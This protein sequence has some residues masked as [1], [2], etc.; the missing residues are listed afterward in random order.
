MKTHHPIP[1]AVAAS[2]LLAG[3]LHAAPI[4][5]ESFN[6]A[7]SAFPAGLE[8]KN[9]G[10]GWGGPWKEFGSS[11]AN[12]GIFAGGI[13]VTSDIA[14]PASG[15]HARVGG[16]TI[17]VGI[18]RNLPAPIGTDETT[19]WISYRTQNNNSSA[20]EEFAVFMT[21]M[22]ETH[23]VLVGATRTVGGQSASDGKFDLANLVAPNPNA[24]IA[25]RDTANHFVVL[26]FDFGVGNSDTV[27]AF[28]DP[29]STT[30][31]NGTGSARL[32]GINATFDGIAFTAANATVQIDE[33]RIGTTLTDVLENPDPYLAAASS[34]SIENHGGPETIEI[35]F[36]NEGATTNLN[37]TGVIVSGPDAAFVTSATADS[38]VAP[39]ESGMIHLDFDPT[40]AGG[41]AGFYQVTLTVA[42]NDPFGDFQTTVNVNVIS[43]FAEV[44]PAALNYGA[45]DTGDGVR[46]LEVTITNSSAE[47]LA[48]YGI[49]VTGADAAAFT[50][51]PNPGE[52]AA[53][54]S[55]V[56]H[57]AFDPALADG[58]VTAALEI[59]TDGVNQSFFTVPLTA[60]VA[61]P[62]PDSSLV[63]HF[64]FESAANPGQDTGLYGNDGTPVGDAQQSSK[65]RVG[66]GSLLLDGTGDLIDLGV[67]SGADYTTQ[68]IANGEGFTLCA[69]GFIPTAAPGA[70]MRFFSSYMPG[71]FV[72]E[73]WGAG[74]VETDRLVG[75]AFGKTDYYPANGTAPARGQWHHFAYVFRNEPIS[76]VDYYVDGAL[77]SSIASATTGVNPANTVGFCIGAL[78]LAGQTQYF[79][80]R[81]DDLRIYDRELVPA[82]ILAIYNAVPPLAGYETWAGSF[83]LDPFGNGAPGQDADLDGVANAIEY[84][85]GS[86]PVNGGERGL[87]QSTR[88]GGQFVVTYQRKLAA[89]AEGFTDRV[90]F[91]PDL[92]NTAAWTT[93]VHGTGGVIIIPTPV[94]AN[95]EQVEVRIPTGGAT[96]MFGRVEVATP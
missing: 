93:A 36:S 58:F 20:T 69:W 12:N 74:V 23:R 83:G 16:A 91:G 27:T 8:S 50:A 87:L 1:G 44:G 15:N 42:S 19:A 28:W 2:V 66:S 94:D 3:A 51:D 7:P 13:T 90:K 31:F 43:P 82:N 72:Q 25:P 92:R 32:S 22:A 80:G 68:L 17:G 6:D 78:G 38:P 33:I 81:I 85:F 41:G 76:R 54:S 57:V 45:L 14:A 47:P 11:N 53:Q 46:N 60:A 88:D 95:T 21:T 70:R 34:V 62:N 86:S 40:L 18:G 56:I 71:G 64:D 26:R 59:D 48:L 84:L 30:D 65:A 39:G 89:L 63:S 79:E 67:A 75:S 73:G 37:I 49:A 61:L 35:P 55:V 52:V 4:A 96:T 77:V 5:I 9:T 29:T 10:R 24:D